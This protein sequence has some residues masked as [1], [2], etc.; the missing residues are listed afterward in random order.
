MTMLFVAV[1]VF[2]VV[3]VFFLFVLFVVVA[4]FF[5]ISEGFLQLQL[6]ELSIRD[7]KINNRQENRVP[8]IIIG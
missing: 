7:T 6:L 1:V 2:F 4:F 8:F 5:L 3:V